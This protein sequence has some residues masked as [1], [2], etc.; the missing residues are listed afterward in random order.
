MLSLDVTTVQLFAVYEVRAS[1]LTCEVIKASSHPRPFTDDGSC[2][3][4]EMN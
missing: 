1:Y 2:G 3:F 4:Q